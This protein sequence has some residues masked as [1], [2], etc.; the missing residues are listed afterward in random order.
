MRLVRTFVR[1]FFVIE[2]FAFGIGTLELATLHRVSR[3]H[4]VSSVF[5][6]SAL[7]YLFALAG[8]AAYTAWRMKHPGR[9]L[10]TAG[11]AVSAMNLVIFPIGTVMGIAGLVCFGRNSYTADEPAPKHKP[12][13]G[14]GTSRRSGAIFIAVQ[15]ACT[16]VA[17]ISLIPWM[18]A[19]WMRGA[20]LH[21]IALGAALVLPVYGAV[22]IHELGHLAAGCCAGLRLVGFRVGL[23]E[24]KLRGARWRFQL[25]EGGFLGGHAAL[26]HRSADRLRERA[27]IMIAG[28]PVGSAL[29]GAA[30]ATAILTTPAVPHAIGMPVV[31]LTMFGISDFV[32]NLMPMGSG[33][34]YSD[35]ARLWQL[36][37]RG[38]W[39]DYLCSIYFM[40]LSRTTPMRPRE[41]PR[42]MVER[43]AVFSEQLPEPSGP[44]GNVYAHYEDS[45]DHERAGQYL[46]Q[47]C[48]RARKGTQLAS[49]LARERAWLEAFHRRNGAEGARWL[50]QARSDTTVADHW[51]AHTAVYLAS[52]DLKKAEEA[53]R[54]GAEIVAKYPEAGVYEVSR[55]QFR[56]LGAALSRTPSGLSVT[57]TSCRMPSLI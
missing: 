44:L 38:P 52:G 41:W 47:A 18:E 46:E 31:M 35:G 16:V 20:H 49:D 4:G 36:W 37:R 34:H 45:G 11:V 22:L 13:P 27:M 54:K 10:R 39:A 48:A 42:D 30:G 32:F 43:M 51:R 33:V 23:L 5:F 28:G 57:E 6:W 21:G 3:E 17:C 8:L 29:L 14:D 9:W 25:A 50:A 56:E 19:K 53:W 26:V 12:L 2:G 15:V 1:W 40:S 55:R 24:L 7:L